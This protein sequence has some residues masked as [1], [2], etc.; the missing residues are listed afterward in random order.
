[1]NVNQLGRPRTSANGFFIG[2]AVFLLI[3][4]DASKAYLGLEGALV[5]AVVLL[6]I[7]GLGLVQALSRAQVNRS[8]RLP[9]GIWWIWI[10][11]SLTNTFL[12][13]GFDPHRDTNSFVFVGSIILCPLLVL[14][15]SAK[16]L[17]I[18]TVL[19][20]AIF[21]LAV[22]MGMSILFDDVG[23]LGGDAY[24]RL[25]SEFN[26]NAIASGAVFA[27]ALIALKGEMGRI[28]WF[29]WIVT[30]ISLYVLVLSGSVKFFFAALLMFSFLLARSAAAALK[31][32]RART[33]AILGVLLVSA[34]VVW[35]PQS[36]LYGRILDKYERSI[37]AEKTEAMFDN[38]A[39]QYL[40][41]Y[42]AFEENPINGIGLRGFVAYSGHTAPLHSEYLV[43]LVEGGLIGSVLFLIFNLSIVRSL[44]LGMK[45]RVIDRR[46]GRLCMLFL[47]V[48]GYLYLGLWSYN[49]PIN[50]LVLA[51]I[52]RIIFEGREADNRRG[53]AGGQVI[54]PVSGML[55]RSA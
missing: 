11:Y 14:L 36:A 24:A 22:R 15:I 51:F 55:S 5:Q 42:S 8:T 6:P 2:A 20:V 39:A 49:I 35:V 48:I 32:R 26:A 33:F 17:A 29:D 12:I 21:A 27:F 3:I 54:T 40:I 41:G 9:L 37:S 16:Q 34:S 19:N 50:W 18:K 44:I 28:S 4:W 10:I 7:V 30:G 38:R 31:S 1:M 23:Y 13:E 47:F 25:G 46:I 52:L 45:K 53:S 43:Q